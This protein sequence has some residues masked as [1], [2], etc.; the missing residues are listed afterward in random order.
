MAMHFK[1]LG[2]TPEHI[3]MNLVRKGGRGRGGLVMV[4]YKGLSMVI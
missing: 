2:G 1:L 4:E 3:F